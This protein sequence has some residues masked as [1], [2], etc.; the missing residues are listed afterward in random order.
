[1]ESSGFMSWMPCAKALRLGQIRVLK[2][3]EQDDS[4]SLNVRLPTGYGKTRT[5]AAAYALLQRAGTVNRLLYVVP[6]IAQC[7]Q[8]EADGAEDL[9]SCGVTGPAT[10][11]NISY[12]TYNAL[13]AHRNNQAQVFVVTIQS[14]CQMGQAGMTA[15]LELMRTGRWMLVIDEYHHYG[16]EKSW[17]RAL[18]ELPYVF[19]LAMSATPYRKDQ[20]E[21]F[22]K[23]DIEVSY[24]DAA[25]EEGVVKRLNCHAYVYQVDAVLPDGTVETFTTSD[26][27]K[28]AGS[29]SPDDIDRWLK[30]TRAMRWSPKYVSPLIFNP[31]DRLERARLST[32][33]PLQA[34]VGAM[35]CSHAQLVCD[36][37]RAMYPDLRIEWVG[38]GPN[39]RTDDENAAAL[40]KFCPKKVDGQRRA[41][42]I[43]LDVLVHVGMA[44]E[45]LDSVFV[46]EVIHLNP[47]SRNNQNNQE[48][49][50]AA[51]LLPTDDPA[52]Q[53]AFINVDSCSA[54][55]EYTGDRIMNAMDDLPPGDVPPDD[56]GKSK[57]YD[58]DPLPDEPKIKIYDVHCIEIDR[59]EVERMATVLVGMVKEWSTRIA[60][61]RK[62]SGLGTR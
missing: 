1:M 29:S 24:R 13:N 9:K 27:I 42:D 59:G 16:L 39:G 20:D 33:L 19:R 15:V 30:V 17:A 8:F 18:A 51:R 53:E 12:S 23:P 31:F 4:K 44:G 37:I 41:I 57:E 58:L 2:T 21:A 48:N 45:G 10:P 25:L 55:T 36:Q 60:Q 52:L 40:K 46:T 43:K 32:G 5:A 7:K 56:P 54:Y 61:R 34:L 38:T 28:E 3:I 62:P 11:R 14:I 49:G 6:T 35:C 26:L 47:A 22:G 50:R